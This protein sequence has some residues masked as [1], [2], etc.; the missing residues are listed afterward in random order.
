MSSRRRGD[1]PRRPRAPH[2]RIGMHDGDAVR[3]EVHVQ[4]DAIGAEI[5]GTLERGQRILRELAWR[6][7]VADAL[8]A[9]SCGSHRQYI[10]RRARHAEGMLRRGVTALTS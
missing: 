2:F 4:L 7:T 10:H 5:D 3:S 9:A 1:W 6:A 8:D